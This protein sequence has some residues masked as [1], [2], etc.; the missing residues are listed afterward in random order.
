[1]KNANNQ[2][3]LSLITKALAGSTNAVE[4][5]AEQV[6]QGDANAQARSDQAAKCMAFLNTKPVAAA[7]TLTW[8]RIDTGYY[9]TTCGSYDAETNER[10]TEGESTQRFWVLCGADGVF[11]GLDYMNDFGTLAEC[12][13]AAEYD[14]F[15]NGRA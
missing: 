12:K 4:K 13:E 14:S 5:T 8:K 11:G 7:T 1:M 3:A 6:K 10:R 2:A 9:R 15:I